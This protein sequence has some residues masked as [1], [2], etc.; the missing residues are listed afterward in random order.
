MIVLEVETG[1]PAKMVV[2]VGAMTDEATMVTHLD[3]MVVG[4]VTDKDTLVTHLD[5]GE[6]CLG[7]KYFV[8]GLRPW[9][10]FGLGRSQDMNLSHG[11]L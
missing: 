10:G 11:G 5:E 6:L 2:G 8:K 4:A 7:Q 3:K 9:R 1:G